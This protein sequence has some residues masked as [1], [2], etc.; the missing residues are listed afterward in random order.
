MAKVQMMGHSFYYPVQDVL[1]LFYG[2]SFF[3]EKNHCCVAG[4]DSWTLNSFR[5]ENTIV[6]SVLGR[7]ELQMS[8]SVSEIYVKRE[9]KRQLYFVLSKLLQ[10]SFPWGSLTGIR[11]TLIARE[12]TSSKEL[13]STYGVRE[14][15]SILSIKTAQIENETLS[16]ISPSSHLMYIGVPFCKS[17]CSY[18][19]FV[20]E[21]THKKEH[22]LPAFKEALLKEMDVFF[23]A[24]PDIQISSLYIGGGTPTVF[25]DA[26]FD[27]FMQRL[28]RL[29]KG[30]NIKEITI[31]AGRPDTITREKLLCLKA[32]GVE[33]ICINPQT[34]QDKTLERIGRKHSVQAFFDAFYLAREIGFSSINTDIIAG[35]PG[36]AKED[37]IRTL[38][39]LI[40]LS[41]ENITVHSLS[42]KRTSHL[43]MLSSFPEDES[44]ITENMVTYAHKRLAEEKYLPY[45]LY[46]QK[47]TL[48]GQEN[49]GYTR[50]GFACDYNTAMMSD[51]FSV[52]A[53]GSG[54]SKRVFSG[55]RLERC[56]GLKNPEEY[57]KRVDEMI[58]K[59]I[60]FFR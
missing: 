57:M 11:P 16:H 50:K 2:Q 19:S 41:P 8:V 47:S 3:D 35:L 26:D 32:F 45:Y 39:G 13:S 14:D 34:L 58:Q 9:I 1:Q 22:L 28:F 40:S 33:R 48:G 37:F 7:P 46:R 10:K 17:R 43:T 25:S 60:T 36:E 38:E 15:K 55:G 53:F 59:K 24:F 52:I 6:T 18:C 56:Q 4:N 44:D 12:V 54:I 49:T 20:S 30:K 29:L 42:K 5:T 27:D 23:Q 31:E 21:D 51:L